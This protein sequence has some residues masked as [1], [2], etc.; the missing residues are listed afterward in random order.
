MTL[1]QEYAAQG[2]P[3]QWGPEFMKAL[4]DKI[5]TLAP[6]L[7]PQQQQQQ[8]QPTRRPGTQLQPT[9]TARQTTPGQMSLSDHMAMIAEVTP[10][11]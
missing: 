3:V 4:D 6:G 5:Y 2:K 9:P 10:V 8:Q 1:A 7:K 11:N